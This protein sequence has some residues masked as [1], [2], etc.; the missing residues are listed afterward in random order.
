M[1]GIRTECALNETEA[2]KANPPKVLV[3]PHVDLNGVLSN[4]AI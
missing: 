3:N 1:P 2:E 4:L